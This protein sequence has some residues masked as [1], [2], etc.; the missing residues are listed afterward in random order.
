MSSDVKRA[1]TT[2]GVALAALVAAALPVDAQAPGAPSPGEKVA[3]ALRRSPVY[4]DSAYADSVPPARQ[5]QLVRQIEKT[6]LPIK[7]ALVPI[8]QG[9]AYDGEADAFAEVVHDRVDRRELILVTG[10]DKWSG[11]LNGYEWPDDAKHQA[12]DAVGAV[13][14]LDETKDAGLAEQT[15]RAIELIA[16]G[17]GTKVYEDATEHLRDGDGGSGDGSLPR[18]D[19]DGADAD[20]NGSAWPLPVAVAVAVALALAAGVLLFFVRARVRVRRR[21]RGSSRSTGPQRYPSATGSP[22]AFPQAVFAAARTA[23]EAALRRQTEAE[24]LALGEAA[25][26]ADTSTPGLQRA[27]D[28]YAAAGTVLD[29]ARGLPDL[30]GVLALVTEG[31]DALEEATPAPLPLCFF[32]PLHGRADLR[33]RWRPL[34]RRDQLDV[35]ACE[36]CGAAVR[37]R[38]APEVLTDEGADGRRVPYFEVP[39]ER[40]VWAATGYGSLLRGADGESEGLAARVGRGD[41]SRGR[42]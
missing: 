18:G 35:A 8:V 37:A 14:F 34:G 22:F 9:D 7:V 12:R 24:V 39:G 25:Q 5:R 28:A 16:E 17:D 13:G 21:N 2:A 20:D 10:G 15:E 19:T 23:D 36:E 41:S 26:S 42:G 11:D 3:D 29:A 33:I 31:R 27:L 1:L 32:N 4:V 40:S 6:G 30:A 38:R